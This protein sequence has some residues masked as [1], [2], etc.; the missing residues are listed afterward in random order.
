MVEKRPNVVA[1]VPIKRMKI[2]AYKL[3]PDKNNSATKQWPRNYSSL[4]GKKA[5][6][7]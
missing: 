1:C 7:F 5:N 2:G 4:P 6:C 3:I